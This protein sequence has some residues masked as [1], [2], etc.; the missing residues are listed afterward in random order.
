LHLGHLPRVVAAE[1]EIFAIGFAS[2]GII[3]Y[4]AIAFLMR[5]L[6]QHTLNVF[7][8][9]RLILAAVVIFWIFWKG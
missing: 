8:G 9:Y 3:G 6:R 4:L 5:Y 2:S 7:A 1:W